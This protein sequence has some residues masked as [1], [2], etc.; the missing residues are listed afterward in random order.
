M[1]T[2]IIAAIVSIGFITLGLLAYT[3]SY[4]AHLHVSPWPKKR[5]IEGCPRCDSFHMP[6][7]YQETICPVCGGPIT[8]GMRLEFDGSKFWQPSTWGNAEFENL[9][10]PPEP[11]GEQFR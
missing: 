5:D 10:F 7:R 2:K 3:C 4:L 1:N 11:R 6:P 9:W 8:R